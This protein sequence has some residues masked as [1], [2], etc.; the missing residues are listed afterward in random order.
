MSKKIDF[1]PI[2][3]KLGKA[4]SGS[5]KYKQKRYYF[6]Q[7]KT[8]NGSSP[9]LIDLNPWRGNPDMEITI[10]SNPAATHTEWREMAKTPLLVSN[11]S[12][13]LDTMVLD[14]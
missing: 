4:I 14:P 5:L 6:T 7:A 8:A 11:A 3:L 2:E 9:I 12:K 1:N 10:I 13:G